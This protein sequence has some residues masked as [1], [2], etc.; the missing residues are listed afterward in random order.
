MKNTY[1][2]VIV[3]RFRKIDPE[4]KCRN[5]TFQ[6][7]DDCCLKCS[8]CYQ[9][10][11]GHNFMSKETAYKIVDLLFKLY[12]EDKEG[13]VINHHTRGLILDFIGGEPFMNVEV[14]EAVMDYFVEKCYQLNHPW[15][16]NFRASISTNGLLYFEPK[17]QAFL[18]KY[19]NF[20][21]LNITIDG[22]KEIHDTCRVDY[23]GKGSFERAMTAWEHWSRWTGADQTHTKVTIA[24]ENLS[25]LGTI[26]DFFLSRGC[27]HIA[28]NPVFEHPWTIEE[29][30]LYYHLL[31]K[32]ADRL[33]EVPDAD[34]TL[35]TETKGKPLLSSDTDNWC[36]GTAAMLAFDPEG[37]AY[38][39]LRYMESSLG[40]D[41]K[42]IIIGNTDGIY[43]TPEYQAIYEDMRKVT[44]QSQS[45]EECINCH[46]ASGC[47]WCSAWNY[48]ETGSYNKR[49]TNI[50]WMHRAEALANVYYWNHYYN[51]KN[52]SKQ[53]PLYLSRDIAKN[54]VTDEEYDFLYKLSTRG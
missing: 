4:V 15:L 19:Y 38:P 25:E 2:N 17:V 3:N 31:I 16:T 30:K 29:A 12:D 23:D 48:Q 52:E 1:D 50:C 20:I 47:A 10:H 37:N 27:K 54:L 35:F 9:V 44:R 33:L 34:S 45:T 40:T 49:S 32:L 24:P 51:L 11:K 36:G 43:N 14:I 6:V 13:A 42:P 8:Y 21:S 22:P 5:V 28:A 46:V 53:F 41:R 7:T 39:C 18:K 26:F